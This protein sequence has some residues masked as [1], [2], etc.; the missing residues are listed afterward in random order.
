MDSMA[1]ATPRSYEDFIPSSHWIREEGSDT[2]VIELPGFKKEHLKVQLDNHT[3]LRTSG[4]RPLTGNQWLRFRG[5]FQIPD[6]YNTGKARAKF[7][8][9]LLTVNLPKLITEPETITQAPAGSHERDSAEGENG[10]G[11]SGKGE[12]GIKVKRRW[13]FVNCAVA[14][15]VI[16]GVGSFV[17]YNF[18]KRGWELIE[19]FDQY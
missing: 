17:V 4:Q 14:A 11:V 16:V 1:R 6:K 5:E 18:R 15:L 7:E 3:N 10:Q 19:Y 12:V 13:L 8:N 2:L 9:G